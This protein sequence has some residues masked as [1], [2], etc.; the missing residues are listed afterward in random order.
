[1]RSWPRA[2]EVWVLNGSGRQGEAGRLS[3]YLSYLG[4]AASAPNQDQ[5]YRAFPPRRSGPTRRRGITSPLT[6]E[7]L[8]LVFG[9]QVTDRRPDRPDRLHGHHGRLDPPAD[10]PAGAVGGACEAYLGEIGVSQWAKRE[11]LPRTAAK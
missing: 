7:A 1:M 9:V 11:S 2:P 5:T 6:A 4:I 8:K 3:Q 10:A